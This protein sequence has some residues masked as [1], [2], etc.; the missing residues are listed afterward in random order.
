MVFDEKNSIMRLI[1]YWGLDYFG[2]H[3]RRNAISELIHQ[4]EIDSDLAFLAQVFR[5]CGSR[6]ARWWTWI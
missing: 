1:H 5:W 3:K 4:F 2:R 6:A